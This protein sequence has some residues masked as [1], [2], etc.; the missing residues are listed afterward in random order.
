MKKTNFLKFSLLALISV[1]LLSGCATIYTTPDFNTARSQHRILAILPFDVTIAVTR[2]P[3]GV[4]VEMLRE[5]EKDEAHVIQSEVYRFFLRQ[6]SRNAYTI[7][8][9]D[10]DE[11]NSRLLREG[12]SFENIRN[13]S[14]AEIA[15]ILNVD[16]VLSGTVH[17]ARPMSMGAAIVTAVLFD[18]GG[19][20][21]KVDVGVAIHNGIDGS[22]LWKYNH[23]YSGGIGSSSENLTR[24][25]M[26][27]ISKK[28]PYKR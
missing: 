5:M 17:R 10:I 12:I 27:Q 20:T 22:L 11:T 18:W 28:F 14:K 19:V 15:K 7:N 3:K 23:S 8:F 21:N 6:M 13:Y 24:E 16:S 1:I 9:Q 25:L 26:R 4:T 2:L